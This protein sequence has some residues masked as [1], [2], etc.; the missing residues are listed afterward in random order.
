MVVFV[1][2]CCMCQWQIA[3][4][5]LAMV[6]YKTGLFVL[7]CNTVADLPATCTSI[8]IGP[9]SQVQQVYVYVGGE[10]QGKD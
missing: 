7:S 6:A 1:W 9:S 2:A 3:H 5:H 4:A 8:I 10:V